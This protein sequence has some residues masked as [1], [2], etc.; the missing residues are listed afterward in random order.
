MKNGS[1]FKG[2][3]VAMVTPFNA[4]GQIDYSGLQ[5]LVEHL[6]GGGV[7]YLVVHGT[8]GESPTLNKEEKR[9]VLDF[10]LEVNNNRLP[11]AVGIGGNNTAAIAEEMKSTDYSGVS[12]ILSVSP[13]YSKPTQA[14]IIAHYKTI[15]A[16]CPLPIILYNVPGRTASNIS[17]ETTLQLA[18]E[19]ENIVAIKEA[20]GDMTQIMRIIHDSP[21]GFEV[22]SGD[23]ALGLPI[24]AA[25]G[26]GVI[27]VIGNAFPKPYSAMV[28]EALA[29]DFS[30]ARKYHYQLLDTIEQIFAEGNPGGIKEALQYLGICERHLRLPLVNVSEKTRLAIYKSMAE[31]ELVS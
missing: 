25:G 8:T 27:S 7:D 17:A 26:K 3:G 4:Q 12:G 15:A 1:A 30:S 16:V 28:H 2:L 18:K 23:D 21:E 5:R 20:S 24:I 22:I 13:A 9:A 14:G 6:I 19:V 31:D 29:G 11:V 10:V